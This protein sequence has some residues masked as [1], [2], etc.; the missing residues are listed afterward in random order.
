MTTF[1]FSATTDQTESPSDNT[2][3]AH[4]QVQPD[5]VKSCDQCHYDADGA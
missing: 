5:P 4:T 2:F 3:E 1:A